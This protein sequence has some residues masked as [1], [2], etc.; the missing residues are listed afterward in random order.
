MMST[1][2]Q[3]LSEIS[4]K[5]TNALVQELGVVDTIRFLNQF[6]AGNG[7][8]TRERAELFSGMSVQDIIGEIKAQRESGA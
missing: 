1:H 2:L 3:P 5:A 8:Y 4:Q 7:N 6:R